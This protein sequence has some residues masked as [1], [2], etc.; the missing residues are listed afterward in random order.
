MDSINQPTTTYPN[1]V[2]L[3]FPSWGQ[4]FQPPAAPNN[5]LDSFSFYYYIV[6][7]NA[8]VDVQSVGDG[9]LSK[10]WEGAVC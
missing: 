10:A 5:Q 2:S 7:A 3:N 9:M 1:G 4:T 6:A 8:G